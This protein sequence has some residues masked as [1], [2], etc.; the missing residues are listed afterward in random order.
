[1]AVGVSRAL[2]A[3]H[4]QQDIRDEIT[5]A[6]LYGNWRDRKGRLREW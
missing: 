5:V 2:S 1:M 6:R 3:V 4:A